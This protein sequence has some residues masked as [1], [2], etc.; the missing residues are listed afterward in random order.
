MICSVLTCKCRHKHLTLT[1]PNT[2][3]LVYVWKGSDSSL[4]PLLLL[5]HQ[6]V[7]PVDQT[8]VDKWAHPPYS[9]YYDGERIWGRGSSDDKSGLM[10]IMIAIETL[11]EKGFAP[12]RGVVLS[13]GFDEEASG[14]YGAQENAK[15]LRAIYGENAFAMVVDEGGGFHES[16][17]SVLYG[18]SPPA[19]S[20]R[21]ADVNYSAVPAIAEKGYIDVR[22]DVHAPGGHSSIPPAHTSIGMLAQMLVKYE[23]HP[24]TPVLKRGT[25][26]Y[27]NVQCYAAHAADMPKTLRRALQHAG[28]SDKALAKAQDLLFEDAAFKALVGTTQAID[29]ISGGVKTNALPEQAFAVVNHRIDTASSV[30]DVMKHDTKLLR[31]FAERFN[32]S[33]TAFGTRLT[34]ADAPAYGSLELSDA[35]GTALEPAPVTP[36]DAA[37]YKLLSG[38][39]KA[40]YAAH[41]ADGVQSAD[42]AVAPGIM[43]GNTDT[44]YYWRLSEHIFRYNHHNAVGSSAL[45]GVHTVNECMRLLFG[46]IDTALT[47]AYS[48]LRRRVPRDDPVL[49]HAHPQRRR[50]ARVDTGNDLVC[51]IVIKSEAVHAVQLSRTCRR[52]V[53]SHETH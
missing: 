19:S 30:A 45:G 51:F 15:A 18:H 40:V 22:V 28:K 7:V 21:N 42:I 52:T 17:G 35:W 6:D 41:R 43:S 34:D 23:A 20:I 16:Y 38:T 48:H 49:Q 27:R 3:G 37:P 33:L 5:A 32:L 53:T 24:Y 10:G 8:T 25:P 9:G 4:K 11:L 36:T 14:V 31:G 39:I 26:T 1:K 50:G 2:Y 46:V 29:L 13:F 44:R 47:N 12:T